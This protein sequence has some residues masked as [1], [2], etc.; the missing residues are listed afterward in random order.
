MAINTS[1]QQLIT[2][3][4]VM[5]SNEDINNMFYYFYGRLATPAEM[6]YWKGKTTGTLYHAFVPNGANGQPD[7]SR[8][9]NYQ[10]AG[11]YK[12]VVAPT[13]TVSG[14]RSGAQASTQNKVETAQDLATINK[15]NHI[16]GNYALIKFSDDPTP[17]DAI[18][19]TKTIWLYDKAKKTY[20]PFVSQK[21]L[22]NFFNLH[23]EVIN[24]NVNTLSSAVLFKDLQG[25]LIQRQYG[26]QDDGSV[27][28]SP[29]NTGS[30]AG[31]NRYGM[32]ALENEKEA[33]VNAGSFIGQAMTTALLSGGL[34][35]A[36]ID[37]ELKNPTNLAKYADALLY[38]G[39]QLQDIYRELKI[40]QLAKTNAAYNGLKGFDTSIPATEFYNTESYK[41]IN[42]D[43][44]VTPPS[45][46]WG[47]DPSLFTNS[48]FKIPSAAFSTL[49]KPLDVN[50][51]EFKAEAEKI[52]AS[53]YDLMMQKSEAN[54]EQEKAL[55]DH[56]WQL[57][58]DNI[59]RKYNISLSD[60]SRTAWNQLQQIMSGMSSRNIMNS[61]I[62]QEA[63]DRYLQ[64]T[65]RTDQFNREAKETQLASENESRLLKS[66]TPREIAD[67]IAQHPES[68]Q[69]FSPSSKTLEYYNVNNL[70]KL[71]PSLSDSE[72]QAMHDTM[73]DENGNYRAELYRTMYSNK[74]DL[75]TQKSTY[76]Q[77]ELYRQKANEEEKAYREFDPN[78]QFSFSSYQ[79]SSLPT[80]GDN[81]TTPVTPKT[82]PNATS[83]PSPYKTAI[84]SLKAY[85]QSGKVVYVQPGTRNPGISLTPP[86]TPTTG[87]TRTTPTAPIKIPNL[88]IM[89]KYKPTDYY[90][91]NKTGSVYLN[92]G[93]KQ[94][95]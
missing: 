56:N 52:K 43:P 41:K 10:N 84:N 65:R 13:S 93:V 18:D 15:I 95:W 70:K 39:Y 28:N 12:D 8:V 67:Y 81:T 55:A 17:N 73:L 76:Q 51:P 45:D 92:A 83:I 2:S 16:D 66:G 30:T 7:Y 31:A 77:S 5:Q 85:D 50:S 62:M 27:P 26:V 53:W 60:N 94:L 4:R 19:D 29:G 91:D 64:D 69:Y 20:T 58:K 54:T 38:G 48:I 86:K 24:K 71:Y 90:R 72:I 34:D 37:S 14:S 78:N 80:S 35:Q 59:N 32:E 68:A 22:S 47:M 6:A 88:A 82:L 40:K 44:S 74:Y 11:F 42:T 3:D 36:T 46:F 23:P 21:A 57:F 89:N 61:G 63:M 9:G 1:I 33:L 25:T 49:V 79:R 87:T 75:G